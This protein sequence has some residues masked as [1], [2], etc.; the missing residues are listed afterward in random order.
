MTGGCAPGAAGRPGTPRA[1]RAAGIPLAGGG[2]ALRPLDA[3]ERRRRDVARGHP[4]SSG[5]EATGSRPCSRPTPSSPTPTYEAM[6]TAA[7]RGRGA[8]RQGT[9]GRAVAAGSARPVGCRAR[10]RGRRRV[11]GE[12]TD[13]TTCPDRRGS[14][15]CAR[16]ARRAARVGQQSPIGEAVQAARRVRRSRAARAARPRD[17]RTGHRRVPRAVRPRAH[18]VLP[19]RLPHRRVVRAGGRLARACTTWQGKAEQ[20]GGAMPCGCD[21]RWLGATFSRT[22]TAS[23]FLLAAAQI[24]FR[25]PG[26]A[27]GGTGQARP[28]RRASRPC[29][30]R[31]GAQPAGGG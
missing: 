25:A 3:R 30:D 31:V 2:H 23:S 15:R 24:A 22:A 14:P 27:C 9:A 26:R 17:I 18:V 6:S 28:S 16:A 19:A 1:R 7:V 11:V 10:R 13:C 12:L 4:A 29:V 20:A 5:G 8:T 21:G